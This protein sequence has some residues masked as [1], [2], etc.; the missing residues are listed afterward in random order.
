VK[1]LPG[2]LFVVASIAFFVAAGLAESP[3]VWVAMGAAFLVFGMIA[4]GR[5]RRT[6]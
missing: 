3:A 5:V 2:L 1:W 6:P 4:M